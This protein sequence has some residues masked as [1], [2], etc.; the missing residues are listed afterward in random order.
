MEVGGQTYRGTDGGLE[1]RV[2]DEENANI[3]GTDAVC[4][5]YVDSEDVEELVITGG[6]KTD[7]KY[8][9]DDLHALPFRF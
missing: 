4:V 2:V 9:A 8:R 6:R 7:F 1:T 3:L 5:H